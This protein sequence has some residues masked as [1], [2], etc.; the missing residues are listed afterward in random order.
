MEKVVLKTPSIVEIK[1]SAIKSGMVL[2]K[3]DGLLKVL[4]GITTM[5]EVERILG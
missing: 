4:Q 1:E 3:Q 2:M 5:E